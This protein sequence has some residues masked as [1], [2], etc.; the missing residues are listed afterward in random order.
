MQQD[1]RAKAELLAIGDDLETISPDMVVEFARN[2][3][4]ALHAYFEWDDTKA[5]ARYRRDQAR[6]L[7]IR[8]KETIVYDGAEVRIPLY[9]SLPQDRGQDS[10]EFSSYR[11]TIDILTDEDRLLMAVKERL[12]LALAQCNALPHPVLEQAADQLKELINAMARAQQAGRKIPRGDQPE[13]PA[14][15]Q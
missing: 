6:G 10:A 4:T 14:L 11:R 12:R 2:P 15:P 3:E 8:W 7:L 13:Q 5:A 9:S 1:K